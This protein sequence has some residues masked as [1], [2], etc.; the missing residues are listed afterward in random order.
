MIKTYKNINSLDDK[1][2]S[3]KI[4][5]KMRSV[6]WAELGTYRY[7]IGMKYSRKGASM[8]KFSMLLMLGVLLAISGGCCTSSKI[9]VTSQ[10]TGE[11]SEE[12]IKKIED[13][14]V[15]LVRGPKG[16]K[17]AYCGGVWVDHDTI[18]T[19]AHCVEIEGRSMLETPPWEKYNPLGDIITFMNHSDL[20][21]QEEEVWIGI[22]NRYDEN[23]DLATLQAL[24]SSSP[25]TI[26][27]IIKREVNP[28]TE[29]HIVGHPAGMA[30]TYVHGHV[31]KIREA[32]VKNESLVKVAQV[33]AP[34]WFGNSG[35]GAFDSKGN[36]VAICSWINP[37]V[38]N[39]SFFIHKD[40]MLGFLAKSPSS[41]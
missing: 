21:K 28:G 16:E 36:L 14:T 17:E 20:G 41:R 34:I 19:A 12:T 39:V 35:G 11:T 22:V 8:K 3:K 2:I 38:P 26:A 15:A 18:I 13:S 27:K 40:E 31:A 33:S 5:K 30:W 37:R 10:P 7:Y 23:K 25:H 1:S 24:G 32:K 29:L 6:L 9:L 4:F